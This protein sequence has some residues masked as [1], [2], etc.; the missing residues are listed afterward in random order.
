M[1]KDSVYIKDMNTLSFIGVVDI[2][3]LFVTFSRI[4]MFLCNRIVRQQ[5]L[6]YFFISCIMLRAVILSFGYT[7]ESPGEL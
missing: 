5:F 6:Y 1:Y 2:L 3:F 7:L 4:F